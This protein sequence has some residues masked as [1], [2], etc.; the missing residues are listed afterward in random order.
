MIQAA[1]WASALVVMFTPGAGITYLAL[2]RRHAHARLRAR[3]RA[4]TLSGR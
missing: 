1:S 2:R 4:Y 3:V